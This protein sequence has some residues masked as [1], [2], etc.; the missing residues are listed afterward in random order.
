MLAN[1]WTEKL[2]SGL[3]QQLVESR[4][5]PTMTQRPNP[6]LGLILLIKFY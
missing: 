3:V 5:Q 4:Y 2:E 1:K 6:T